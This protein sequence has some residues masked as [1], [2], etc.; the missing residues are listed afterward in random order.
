[1]KEEHLKPY[2]EYLEDLTKTFNKIKYTVIPRAQNQLADALATLATMVNDKGLLV[3]SFKV[4]HT[5]K[6]MAPLSSST[7]HKRMGPK[8]TTPQKDDGPAIPDGH[9][10]ETDEKFRMKQETD[11][12]RRPTG[13]VWLGLISMN[14]CAR[15]YLASQD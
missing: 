4:W 8:V 13:L 3:E 6:P 14:I 9:L 15:K 10:Y 7:S 1:M 5:R 11:K 2:Q 12:V